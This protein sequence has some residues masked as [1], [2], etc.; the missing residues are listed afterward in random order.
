MT[1]IAI[2]SE[3]WKEI[4]DFPCYFVSNLGRVKSEKTRRYGSSFIMKTNYDRDGY[5][6]L[7]LCKDN[8]KYTRHVHR[9]VAATF[10]ENQSHLPCINH[11][12]ENKTNNRCDNLEW[13]TVAY[14]NC[15]NNGYYRRGE[16]RRKPINQFSLDGLLIKTWSCRSEIERELGFSGGNISSVCAGK[17]KKANGFI[18]KFA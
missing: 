16:K 15:Y 3:I 6:M 4:A 7:V 14:N 2:E 1:D 17:R 9:L 13:C 8:K 18:W 11:I 12:D 10:I 5:L